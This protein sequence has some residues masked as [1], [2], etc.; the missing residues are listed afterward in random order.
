LDNRR[1]LDWLFE[2]LADSDSN[3]EVLRVRKAL[4]RTLGFLPSIED[5]SSATESTCTGV[6]PAL[7][8]GM[9][10]LRLHLSTFM[11]ESDCLELSRKS[12][13]GVWED[14]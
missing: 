8:R 7:D 12:W 13:T 1:E 6:L 4:E 5:G 10:P 14:P 9:E 3:E 2:W 11:M